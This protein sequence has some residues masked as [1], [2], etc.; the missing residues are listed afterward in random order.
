MTFL[1]IDS[2]TE[3][4]ACIETECPLSFDSESPVC[5]DTEHPVYIE[6]ECLSLCFSPMPC[7]SAE[8]VLTPTR[9]IMDCRVLCPSLPD[10]LRKT[11]LTFCEGSVKFQR[12]LEVIGSL[13]I[14]SDSEKIGTF[15][16]DEQVVRSA[17]GDDEKTTDSG[18][19][20]TSNSY[21]G[22]GRQDTST[23]SGKGGFVLPP[24]K[25]R[26]TQKPVRKMNYCY[27]QS[28]ESSDAE[29]ETDCVPLETNLNVEKGNEKGGEFMEARPLGM[30]EKRM[31]EYLDN[32]DSNASLSSEET[33]R[34]A[35]VGTMSPGGPV[36]YE[37]SS[38]RPDDNISAGNSHA[39]GSGST[40]PG[41]QLP[42]DQTSNKNAS[43]TDMMQDPNQ[44]IVKQ[45]SDLDAR[46][47]Y[48]QSYARS[49]ESALILSTM[50][51]ANA[52]RSLYSMD[53]DSDGFPHEDKYSPY[54][55]NPEQ[56]L[57]NPKKLQDIYP[58]QI[59]AEDLRNGQYSS[60]GENWGGDGV[61]TSGGE[62]QGLGLKDSP[63]ASW[64]KPVPCKLCGR[65]LKS[66]KMLE[67][68]MNTAHTHKTIY[69]CKQ[70]GKVFYAASSLHSHKK[71]TH[72]SMEQK[73]KCPH[74]TRFYAFQSELLRHIDTAHMEMASLSASQVGLGVDVSTFWASYQDPQSL[75]VMTSQQ[76]SPPVSQQ[77]SS[78]PT[79]SQN[80]PEDVKPGVTVSSAMGLRYKCSMCGMLLKSKEC[81]SLHINAKHTQ[82]QAYPCN[83]CGK[84][85]YA[86]SSRF[87][88]IR[89]VH[90]STEQKFHCNFCD[91]IFT[92][93]YELRNHL[94]LMHRNKLVQQAVC[95][96][97]ET[98][99]AGGD[100]MAGCDLSESEPARAEPLAGCDMSETQQASGDAM[101]GYDLTESEPASGEP[102]AGSNLS[103]K[104]PAGGEA[105]VGCESSEMQPA[106]GEAMDEGLVPQDLTNGTLSS[107]QG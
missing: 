73:Y 88:H 75:G 104:Q 14:R 55:H 43:E 90:A 98:E 81:L 51:A 77:D 92:F 37:V 4:P 59:Y 29:S 21:V 60:T 68:H 12:T 8:D 3:R 26:K 39:S 18:T 63:E 20:V 36:N 58:E 47:V 76:P 84:V 13:H 25:S 85:F 105:M 99:R 31:R 34:Q 23:S 10:L 41:E 24:K 49:Y 28:F 27:M 83:V 64:D 65:A 95:D 70:C 94:K 42:K 35:T 101:A 16:L 46:F 93:H 82:K 79:L 86:P 22:E 87:C 57:G 50:A 100:P 40:S 66:E 78:S 1:C 45:E 91:K 72:T 9:T 7:G 19:K 80:S 56:G 30:L 106:R 52:A 67:I 102:N 62:R 74:C 33:F 32:A 61:N 69:P 5:I 53:I 103:V 97:S 44:V 71:R 89:R 6:T 17:V 15:L 54:K 107:S 48:D 96:L 11:I 38:T 2:K